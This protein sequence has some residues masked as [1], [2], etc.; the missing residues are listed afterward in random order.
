MLFLIIFTPIYI[1]FFFVPNEFF[2]QTH[3]STY[4]SIVIS[5]H[6][7]V[8]LIYNKPKLIRGPYRWRPQP[9]WLHDAKVMEFVGVNIYLLFRTNKIETTAPMRLKAF[10]AY[11]KGQIIDVTQVNT[12]VRVIQALLTMKSI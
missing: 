5:D 6:G 4:E 11:Q 2:Q 12:S 3:N 10:K 1:Y 9:K 7:L 8:M